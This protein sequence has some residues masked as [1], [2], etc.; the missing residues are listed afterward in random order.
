MPLFAKEFT[1]EHWGVAEALILDP[2]ERH[3]SL[4]APLAADDE[5]PDA[6]A[7]HEAV[8]SDPVP[9]PEERDD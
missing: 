7:H 6:D 8:Y 5:A 4:Q 9:E 2:D 3:I 1:P